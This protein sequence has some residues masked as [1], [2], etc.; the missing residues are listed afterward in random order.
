MKWCEHMIWD[1]GMKCFDLRWQYEGVYDEGEWKYC[2]ICGKKRPA[3]K[4]DDK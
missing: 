3:D 4:K 2:P 1:S